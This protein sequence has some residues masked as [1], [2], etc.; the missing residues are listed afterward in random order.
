MLTC[1]VSFF[2]LFSPVWSCQFPTHQ[3]TLPY[4]TTGEGRTNKRILHRPLKCF[5]MLFMQHHVA[6]QHAYRKH[7][8]PSSAYKW[9]HRCSRLAS[10]IV[11]D[12]RERESM[13]LPPRDHGCQFCRGINWI[14]TCD[15]PTLGQTLFCCATWEPIMRFL[16]NMATTCQSILLVQSSTYL[17]SCN[18]CLISWICTKCLRQDAKIGVWSFLGGGVIAFSPF[19]SIW[20]AIRCT[21]CTFRTLGW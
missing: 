11:I 9:S 14:Q 7:Y 4:H 8:L 6:A 18:S 1:E 21:G 16:N 2:F 13:P 3:L 5:K 10:V 19:E 12:R 20:A 15:L 17:N